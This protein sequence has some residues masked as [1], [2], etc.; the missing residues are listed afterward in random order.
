MLSD[1][2]CAVFGLD[3]GEG[4]EAGVHVG[5]G[6]GEEAGDGVGYA[7]LARGSGAVDEEGEEVGEAVWSIQPRRPLQT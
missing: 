3:G 4:F 7:V 6:G 5:E 2:L 1:G